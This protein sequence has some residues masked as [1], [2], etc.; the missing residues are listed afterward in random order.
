MEASLTAQLR[1]HPLRTIAVLVVGYV[2]VLVGLSWGV[3]AWRQHDRDQAFLA[4]IRADTT[5]TVGDLPDEQLLQ[6]FRVDCERISQGWS[7]DRALEAA[8]RNYVAVEGGASRLVVLTNVR[9][10]YAASAP[11]C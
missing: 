9:A 11:N 10:L 4:A 2:V 6:S 7:L 5:T 1:R 3:G 8:S